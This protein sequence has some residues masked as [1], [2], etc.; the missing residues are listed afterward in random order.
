MKKQ[1]ITIQA[2]KEQIERITRV[3]LYYA[4]CEELKRRDA[5]LYGEILNGLGFEDE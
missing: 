1:K 4:V 2:S 5:D 3:E